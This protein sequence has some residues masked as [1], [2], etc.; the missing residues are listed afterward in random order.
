MRAVALNT[1]TPASGSPFSRTFT[2]ISVYGD[3]G[4]TTYAIDSSTPD[5]VL[6]SDVVADLLTRTAPLLTFT[7]GPNGSGVGEKWMEG[8]K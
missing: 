4:L 2:A 3:H 5:G 7:T 1:H 8:S 6:A